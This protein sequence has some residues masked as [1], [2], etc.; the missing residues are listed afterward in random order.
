MRTDRKGVL[1][2]VAAAIFYSIG[3]LC[4]KLIP[5]SGLSINGGRSAIAILVLMLYLQAIH[6]KI[7]F[8][9][10]ILLGS[11]GVFGT[12]TL[13]AIANKMTTAANAIVLQFTAPIFVLLFG[14]VFFG[15]KP[16]KLDVWSCAV[17]FGGIA[18]VFVDS[19]SM[20]GMLGNVIALFSGVSY[21]VMFML[22]DLPDSDPLSSVFWGYL[23]SALVGVPSI[24]GE[25]NFE[26]RVLLTLLI[27]GVFQLALGHIC[28]CIGIS[29]T[30]PVTACLAS[31]IEPV[32]NPILVAI[33]YGETIG[34]FALVGA[35]IVI[36]GVV[37]YN[38]I[39]AKTEK[40]C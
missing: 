40:I 9:R 3:G 36:A 6:H 31:G 28:L 24:M 7:R 33:F 1:F 21:A 29:T 37:A 39:D 23:M 8:N 32:L 16:K 22:N 11:I 10:W 20:G 18:F 15:R 13:F 27:L 4:I 25:T 19:M 26:P 17:V 30:P 35:V 38:M 12:N 14:F 2:V 34:F 5:W